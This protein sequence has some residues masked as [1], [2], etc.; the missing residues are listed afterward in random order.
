MLYSRAGDYP[1]GQSIIYAESFSPNTPEGAC[2]VC[3]G[4]GRIYEVTEGSMV[5]NPSLTIRERA[6]AA[7]PTAWG[8]Q[9]QRD[10][11][12]TLGYDVDTPWHKLPKKDR[13]WILFTED[14]PVVPVIS[15]LYT[16]G[17]AAGPE[18]QRAAQLYGHL[19]QC[20]AACAPLLRHYAKP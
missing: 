8:G 4:Q 13:D 7:W 6:V 19:Y 9:N 20:K 17:D 5:P 2:A 14:Q 12:V 10:I 15:R 1:A 3:H 16:G 18:A 11:L